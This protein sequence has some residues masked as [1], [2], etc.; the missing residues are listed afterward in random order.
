MDEKTKYEN[1]QMSPQLYD[2]YICIKRNTHLLILYSFIQY[3]FI[4]NT[5]HC[6]QGLDF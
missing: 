4:P 1:A 2:R 6:E 3:L 5:M